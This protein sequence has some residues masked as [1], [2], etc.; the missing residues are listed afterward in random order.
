MEQEDI[1]CTCE[2]DK[3][4]GC[5]TSIREKDVVKGIGV[6]GC[7][8]YAKDEKKARYYGTRH[9]PQAIESDES[10]QAQAG[11]RIGGSYE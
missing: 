9:L 5:N 1:C 10:A 6:I 8:Q 7:K 4:W 3:P 2:K 11:G